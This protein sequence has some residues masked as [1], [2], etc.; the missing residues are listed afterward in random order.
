VAEQNALRLFG[1]RL[2]HLWVLDDDVVVAPDILDQL[3]AGMA[4]TAAE[5]AVPM[6]LNAAGEVGWL[7]G[8]ID[9]ARFRALWRAKS[10]ADYLQECG[11]EPVS[12]S[13]ATGIC[14]LCTR[15]VVEEVG[16]HRP[17][18]WIRGE[19]L[20]YSLRITARFRGVFVPT[21]EVAHLPPVVVDDAETQ[22]AEIVKEGAHVQNVSYI[23]LHL[24]HGRRIVSKIPGRYYRLLKSSHWVPAAW[25]EAMRAFLYGAILGRPA[26]ATRRG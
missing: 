10:T 11:S 17:D 12:F 3:L 26:G 6:I 1:D 25:A 23:G 14:L 2:T 9:S 8:L 24:R 16:P 13:W 4:Q 21:T 20:E 18:F 19:D 5:A 7:S 15:R 22:R